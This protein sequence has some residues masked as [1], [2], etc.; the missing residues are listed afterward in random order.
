MPSQ[1]GKIFNHEGEL[2]LEGECDLAEDGQELTLHPSLDSGLLDR[3]QE[4][5]YLELDDGRV[6]EI[7]RHHLK[8][9]LQTPTGRRVIYRL[10]ILRR[11]RP[12]SLPYDKPPLST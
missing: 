1:L 3:Q 11:A 6:Y 2:V 7:A 12:A 5:L 4:P 9:N 8:L 10:H